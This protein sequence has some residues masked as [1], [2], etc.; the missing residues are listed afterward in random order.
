MIGYYNESNFYGIPE[1]GFIPPYEILGE[2]ELMVMKYK[3]FRLSNKDKS[4]NNLR[5]FHLV[6]GGY[7]GIFLGG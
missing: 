3:Y 6:P 7:G 2:H 5:C 1:E 4:P